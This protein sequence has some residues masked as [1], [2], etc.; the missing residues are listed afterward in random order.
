MSNKA[1]SSVFFCIL[2]L[3][4]HACFTIFKGDYSNLFRI[5]VVSI[6]L[7]I[8]MNVSIAEKKS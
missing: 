1:I 3:T 4:F 8:I 7:I 2:L 5:A 6:Y